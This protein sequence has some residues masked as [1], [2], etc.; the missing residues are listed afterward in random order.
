VNVRTI[1]S[2]IMT[3]YHL[4]LSNFSV[5]RAPRDSKMDCTKDIEVIFKKNIYLVQFINP[6]DSYILGVGKS[7]WRF[8]NAINGKNVTNFFPHLIVS[9]IYSTL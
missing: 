1:Q 4:V 7:S 8:F 9:G 3:M 2:S 6:V 5:S